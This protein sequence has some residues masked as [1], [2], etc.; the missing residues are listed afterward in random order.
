[1]SEIPKSID[2]KK[3]TDY[4][5]PLVFIQKLFDLWIESISK[6][7]AILKKRPYLYSIKLGACRDTNKRL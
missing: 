5:P 1:V 3:I 7:T 2:L 4:T 6:L